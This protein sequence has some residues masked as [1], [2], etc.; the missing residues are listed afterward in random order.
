ML[1]WSGRFQNHQNLRNLHNHG[2]AG[3]V[4]SFIAVNTLYFNEH[5]T[6]Q[7]T[8]YIT[9]NNEHFTLQWTFYITVSKYFSLQRERSALHCITMTFYTKVNTEHSTLQ[10]ALSR[11]GV[12]RAAQCDGNWWKRLCPGWHLHWPTVYISNEQRYCREKRTLKGQISIVSL[13]T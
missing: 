8:F 11:W 5:S 9:M 12:M 2:F 4:H 7:C 1:G 6:L 13:I 10:L 3:F